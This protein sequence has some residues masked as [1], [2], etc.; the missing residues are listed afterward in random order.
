M[1]DST[2]H[3]GPLLGFD[4]E[5][6]GIDTTTARIV[7]AAIVNGDDVASWLINPGI[8]IP[9]AASNVHGISTEHARANGTEPA[10]A[11][12]EIGRALTKAAEEDTP[13][14]VY[15][16]GYDLTLLSHELDRYSLPQVP[17]ERLKVLD[18]FVLD[19]KADKFR[20]GKRTLSAVCT[21]YDVDL[22]GA[23]SADA[24][25]RAAVSLARAIG[26]RH[27]ALA[28][29]NITELHTAQIAWHADDA[30]SLEAYFRRQG[31]QETIDRRWPLQR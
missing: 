19:K 14:V 27:K 30:A 18:P 29:M 21:H 1:D 16:A 24:D 7:T 6:T 12:S 10:L 23:H 28:A 4:T 8:D 15:R 17:W 2:W 3:T 13:V 9:A 5:T 20:R 26:Q 25:A 31:K 22:S 11:L